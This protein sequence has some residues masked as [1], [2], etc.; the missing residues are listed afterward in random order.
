MEELQ[1]ETYFYFLRDKNNHPVITVCLIKYKDWFSRGLAICSKKDNFDKG[2]G[3]SIAWWRA[4]KGLS[5]LKN[6]EKEPTTKQKKLGR[7]NKRYISIDAI[8]RDEIVGRMRELIADDQINCFLFKT[9]TFDRNLL[10]RLEKKI[11][12]K[13]IKSI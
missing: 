13:S 12:E 11:L 10:T 5:I 4:Q 3:K 2:D 7:I 9:S 1:E 6:A 8:G